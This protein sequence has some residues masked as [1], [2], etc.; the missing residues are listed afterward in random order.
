MY[1]VYWTVSGNT[2]GKEFED[3]TEALNYC[4]YARRSGCRFVTMCS[5]IADMVGE[6]GVTETE[7]DYDWKKRRV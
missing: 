6:W 2:H 5:E 4:Q 1:K 3:M 7:P